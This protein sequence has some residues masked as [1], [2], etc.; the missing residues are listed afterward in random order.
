MSNNQTSE[1][2]RKNEL[3]KYWNISLKHSSMLKKNINN[4]NIINIV[5]S[6]YGSLTL[7]LKSEKCNLKKNLWQ[8]LL[9]VRKKNNIKNLKSSINKLHYTN[10]IYTN[11][12]Y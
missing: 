3:R 7:Y 11:K 6:V 9:N 10:I 5:D 12:T 4:K 1:A 2:L 8:E